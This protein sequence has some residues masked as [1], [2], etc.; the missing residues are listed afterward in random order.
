MTLFI[1]LGPASLP[2][3]SCSRGVSVVHKF[4]K[5]TMIPEVESELD[6]RT[7]MFGVSDGSDVLQDY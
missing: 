3:V 6:P 7:N 2:R 1:A 5:R 4:F